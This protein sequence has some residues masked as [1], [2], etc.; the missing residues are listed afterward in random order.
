MFCFIVGLPLN[1][2]YEM[3]LEVDVAVWHSDIDPVMLED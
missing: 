1:V 2:G 3:D